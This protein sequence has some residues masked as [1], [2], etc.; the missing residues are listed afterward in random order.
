MVVRKK[1]KWNKGTNKTTN[2]GVYIVLHTVVPQMG[3]RSRKMISSSPFLIPQTELQTSTRYI[4][5]LC[6]SKPTNQQTNQQVNKTTQAAIK[7][8]NHVNK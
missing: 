8:I 2:C 5:K 4:R 3:V 1:R 7:P 6:L